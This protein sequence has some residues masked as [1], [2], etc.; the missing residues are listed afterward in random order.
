MRPC[1]HRL[2]LAALLLPAAAQAQ[3]Q[4]LRFP[5]SARATPAAMAS[6][7]PDPARQ[8]LSQLSPA[9]TPEALSARVLL[10][11]TTGGQAS[12]GSGFASGVGAWI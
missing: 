9:S 12:S 7:L 5:P 2:L 10:Q 8:A 4:S 1:L 11:L 6:A 3:S